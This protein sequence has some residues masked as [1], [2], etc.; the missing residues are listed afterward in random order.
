MYRKYTKNDIEARN[1]QREKY[2]ATKTL[3]SQVVLAN[4]KS[5]T[6]REMKKQTHPY[7]HTHTHTQTHLTRRDDDS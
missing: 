1:S 5:A 6:K 4:K 7:T 3:A 2:W